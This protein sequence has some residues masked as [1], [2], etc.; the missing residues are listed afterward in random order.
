MRTQRAI[1]T[2]NELGTM[3]GLERLKELDLEIAKHS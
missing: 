2:L 3:K 1:A